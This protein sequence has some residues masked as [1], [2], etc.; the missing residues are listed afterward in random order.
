MTLKLSDPTRRRKR[1]ITLIV[2]Q[3]RARVPARREDMPQPE[4]AFCLRS[5]ATSSQKFP[6]TGTREICLCELWVLAV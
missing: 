2:K 5:G 4:G 1:L 3:G 6:K